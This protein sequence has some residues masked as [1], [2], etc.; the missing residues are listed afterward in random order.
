MFSQAT[1]RPTRNEKMSLPVWNTS[2]PFNSRELT[3]SL[4]PSSSQVGWNKRLDRTVYVSAKNNACGMGVKDTVQKGKRILQEWLPL[5]P[6]YNKLQT[7]NCANSACS[8]VDTL[9]ARLTRK[10]SG[11]AS[12]TSTLLELRLHANLMH[13]VESLPASIRPCYK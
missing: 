12:D 10:R 3:H 13:R 6:F 5:R 1:T 4:D 2:G 8:Q 9:L 7:L 11:D